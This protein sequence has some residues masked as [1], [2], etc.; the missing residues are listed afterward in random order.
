MSDWMK[1]FEMLKKYRR[2]LLLTMAVCIF[3]FIACALKLN[4]L[5]AFDQQVYTFVSLAISKTLTPLMRLL[6]ELGGTLGLVLLCAIGALLLMLMK[7]RVLACLMIS[8]LAITAASNVL[9][10]QLFIRP[11]PIG[12]R[13]IE[14]DGYSFP[15]GHSMAAMAFYGYLIYLI[16]HKLEVKWQKYL[17]TCLLSLLIL[18][19]MLSR[20]YLGV[21]YASDVL[22]GAAAAL[23]ILICFT[24]CTR[25]YCLLELN[26]KKD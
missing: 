22:A 16:W 21:H 24:S 4:Q 19:I 14:I 5:S 12:Y 2:Q 13:L 9:L 17:F 15:S 26:D 6:T 3:L 11:R 7:K 10:K 8:N 23:A 18:L 25:K 20:I 1:L